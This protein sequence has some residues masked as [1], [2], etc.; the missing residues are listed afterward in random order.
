VGKNSVIYMGLI[1]GPNKTDEICGKIMVTGM[2]YQG[3][4]VVE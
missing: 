1:L 3:S 4:N 2:M